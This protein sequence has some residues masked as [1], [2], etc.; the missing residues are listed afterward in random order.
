MYVKD[1]YC[2]ISTSFLYTRHINDL[3]VVYAQLSRYD[4][5]KFAFIFKYPSIANAAITVEAI[6]DD[7]NQF[8]IFRKQNWNRLGDYYV[9]MA[10]F[11]NNVCHLSSHKQIIHLTK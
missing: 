3:H 6:F 9:I 4:S 8:D 10:I 11:D 7:K 5:K 1:V 2:G